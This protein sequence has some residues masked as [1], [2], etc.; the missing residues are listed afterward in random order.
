M[1][2]LYRSLPSAADILNR[3]GGEGPGFNAM[4]LI[5]SL[6]ILAGL[7]VVPIFRRVRPATVVAGGRLLNAAG[8]GLVSYAGPA[9]S[10]I[11]L[12]TAFAILGAGIGAAETISN[13]LILAAVP[14][15]QAGAASAISETAYETG[16]VLG[17]AVLGSILNAAYRAHVQIPEGLD[18]AAASSARETIGGAA[19]A[20]E[21]LDPQTGAALMDSAR[22]AFDSGV[23]YTGLI[24]TVLMLAATVMA[25]RT[26]R[27]ARAN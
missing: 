15:H 14:A 1:I 22:H 13:D 5:L 12:L 2:R 3:N 8:F 6:T 11:G 4:R 25:L 16:S 10:D 19:Q 21:G 24:G 9:G 23:L 18:D 20:A 7:A 27:E 17:T 26:L